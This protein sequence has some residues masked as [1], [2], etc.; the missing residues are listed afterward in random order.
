MAAT[1]QIKTI[2]ALGNALG[3]VER[4]ADDVLH[5]MIQ[6]YFGID[7]VKALSQ[8]QA[9][10]LIGMLKDQ[11]GYTSPKP[12]NRCAAMSDG[13]KKKVWRLM[14]RLQAFDQ[15]P[16]TVSL[17]E[18]LCGIIRRQ[19]RTDATPKDPFKWLDYQAGNRLIE[20]VKNY[21]K[22]AER[23]AYKRSEDYG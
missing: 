22:T 10:Q 8:E 17:G 19:L 6:T 2:Y 15:T 3:I 9:T 13:Q 1:Q 4:G 20:F 7:S 21:V 18:R 16:S 23:T 11:C 14:Y 12:D 5:Q